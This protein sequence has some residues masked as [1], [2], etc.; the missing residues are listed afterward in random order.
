[1]SLKKPALV[2][3]G[4][5]LVGL[6]W[7]RCNQDRGLQAQ[8]EQAKAHEAY[9]Q[10][11][12]NDASLKLSQLRAMRNIAG[13]ASKSDAAAPPGF[14]NVA[15]PAPPSNAA[16]K[17]PEAGAGVAGGQAAAPAAVPPA[18]AQPPPEQHAQTVSKAEAMA[19]FIGQPATGDLAIVVVTAPREGPSYLDPLMKRIAEDAEA[20]N[21]KLDFFLHQS[22][23]TW[24]D[25][26]ARMAH[27][28]TLLYPGDAPFP[29]LAPGK[30][31]KLTMVCSAKT[32]TPLITI[33]GRVI[34]KSE[35]VGEPST[36]W[37]ISVHSSAL[38][39]EVQ[40]HM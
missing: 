26:V 35:C 20:D 17:A 6:V 1:M 34:R 2:A 15:A 23:G 28:A 18:A 39:K 24:S 3:A 22:Q 25:D 5:I 27:G 9:L 14:V 7:F 12:L 33:V 11:Q 37:T 13:A 16:V 40:H 4:L 32:V 29:A 10:A 38:V 19:P 8:L 30:S 21:V 36:S 31:I